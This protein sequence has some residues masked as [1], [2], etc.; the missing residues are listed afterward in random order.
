MHRTPHR[1]SVSDAGVTVDDIKSELKRDVSERFVDDKLDVVEFV[2]HV[3]GLSEKTIN[4]IL[5]AAENNFTPSA[6]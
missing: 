5:S 1:R 3:W 2:R 4:T 6:S